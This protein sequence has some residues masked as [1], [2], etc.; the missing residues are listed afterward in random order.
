MS[1]LNGNKEAQVEVLQNRVRELEQEN[2]ALL[3]YVDHPKNEIKVST[4]SHA[5]KVKAPLLPMKIKQCNLELESAREMFLQ[6]MD[7]D[8]EAKANQHAEEV[9]LGE[10]FHSVISDPSEVAEKINKVKMEITETSTVSSPNFNAL[11]NALLE[12]STS[13]DLLKGH[14]LHL[15]QL[16]ARHFFLHKQCDLSFSS[17][18][19]NFVGYTAGELKDGGYTAKELK[20]VGYTARALKDGGYTAKELKDVGYTPKELKDGG[21]T[22]K[23]LKD[24]GYTAKDLK[25]VGYTAKELKDV[26]Y[27]AKELKDGGY[28]LRELK[29]GG[30]TLRELKDGGY[31]AKELKDVGY[32][33]GELKD[34]GYT[35]GELKDGGYTAGEL[36]GVGFSRYDLFC[37]G[38][39]EVEGYTA[40]VEL[41]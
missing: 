15:K 31:T 21:Y 8:T 29:D 6:A 34:G 24:V 10:L 35:A 41:W 40:T 14:K 22:A 32:T 4:L 23:E 18:D 36:R 3:K 5:D 12:T 38:Y 37:G 7:R 39:K 25:D 17:Q 9:K 13:A 27:T 26:G 20:D 28:T 33:A 2:Q 30:Y 19:T 16:Q 11:K 1:E